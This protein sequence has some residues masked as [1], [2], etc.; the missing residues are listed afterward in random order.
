MRRFALGCSVRREERRLVIP[1]KRRATTQ[2]TPKLRTALRV[3]PTCVS[4][5]VALLAKAISIGRVASPRGET[6]VG[7]THARIFM[8]WPLVA[9]N[10]VCERIVFVLWRLWSIQSK[11]RVVKTSRNGNFL[12][13]TYSHST[14]LR[15]FSLITNSNHSQS[16]VGVPFCN[17]SIII[18]PKLS[19]YCTGS[20]PFWQKSINGKL[21]SQQNIPKKSV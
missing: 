10:G 5:V 2:Y 12:S 1:N 3:E 8:K 20:P 15:K 19:T 18:Q 17:R 6:H 4:R 13:K 7:S 14:G 9:F 11:Y 16:F 21:R